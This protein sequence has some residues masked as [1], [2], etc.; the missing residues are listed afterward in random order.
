MDGVEL[1][2]NLSMR[3]EVGDVVRCSRCLDY[4]RENCQAMRITEKR[5]NTY[6]LN[7]CRCDCVTDKYLE[8]NYTPPKEGE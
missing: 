5:I 8:F 2:D 4:I 3:F 1:K 7:G 6:K